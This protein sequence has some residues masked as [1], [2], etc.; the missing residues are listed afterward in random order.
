MFEV[1]A[2]LPPAVAFR[3]FGFPRVLPFNLTVS[4]TSRCNSRCATCNIWQSEPTELELDELSAIFRNLGRAPYWFTMSGGEPFL[5]KDIV[6]ICG[7]AHDYCRPGIMNI[8]T[9]GILSH[10]IPVRVREILK[11]CP[12]TQL[13]VNLSIDGIGA[14]HDAIRGVDGNFE[15]AIETYQALRQIDAPN[16][17]LG[18][19]T[20][21]SRFNIDR[22]RKLA[23]FVATLQPDSYIAE[24][25]EERVELGTIDTGITPDSRDFRRAA[26]ILTDYMD[27]HEL[28]GMGKLAQAFRRRYYRMVETVLDE[29]RQA[30]PCYAGF[31]S[32]QIAAGGDVWACCVRADSMGNLRDYG[33]NFHR[34]W[35]GERAQNIRQEITAG[36]CSCP[37]AN[38]SYTNMLCHVPTLAGVSLDL[39]G[40]FKVFSGLVSANPTAQPARA[41]IR[42]EA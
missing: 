26:D 42:K 31:A 23:D 28:D 20:V 39:A 9:N 16:F 5:R 11:R 13:V 22:I 14:E 27:Q 17:T 6:D 8:P 40:S 41:G 10:T 34:I 21:I 29:Q 3:T 37:L 33:Y 4:L 12:G 32:A 18:V 30:V 19:H 2:K 35:S 1:L 24:I 25:A 36:K 7:A 15:K 38:A